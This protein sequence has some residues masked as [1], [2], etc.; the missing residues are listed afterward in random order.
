MMFGKISVAATAAFSPPRPDDFNGD[1]ISDILW[2]NSVGGVVVWTMNGGAISSSFVTANGTSVAVDGSWS[3]AGLSDFNGDGSADILWRNTSG[4][5]AVWFMSGPAIIGSSD[6]T[7]NGVAVKPDAS[8]SVGGVGDFNGNGKA[9]ILWRNTSGEVA[10]W[11]MDGSTIASSDDITLHGVAARPDA[12]WSAAGVGNFNGDG[13]GGNADILW[14]NATTGELAVWFMNGSTIASSADV[15]LNGVSVRPDS[16]WSL[17]GINDFN[18]DKDA[19]MLWR[20]TDGT[21]VEWGLNG[22]AIG[23]VS[24]LTFNGV[25]VDPDASWH[26][27]EIGDFNGDGR[28]DILWRNDNGT[29]SE[30][31]MSGTTI[32]QTVTPAANGIAASP[33]N[34]WAIQARPTTFA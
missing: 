33:D 29:L 17:A 34:T 28:S 12:T 7:S 27:V 25:A 21:L 23:F 3:V 32:N 24:A 10:V 5:V 31:L 22:T 19:D 30:W 13:V 4:E 14:R 6:V 15:T 18:G 2:R 1:G 8:W 9:D 20:N 26:V 16:S 11:L